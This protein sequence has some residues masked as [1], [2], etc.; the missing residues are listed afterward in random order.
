MSK[1]KKLFTLVGITCIFVLICAGLGIPAEKLPFAGQTVNISTIDKAKINGWLLFKDDIEKE[2][3]IKLNTMI[4][5]AAAAYEKQMMEFAAGTGAFDI[6]AFN[7]PW[8]GDYSR[9]LQPL[10]PLAEKAG[11]NFYLDDIMPVFRD[12]YMSWNGTW[13]AMTWD[14]DT[15]LLLYRKDIFD[16]LGLEPPTTWEDYKNK[17]AMLTGW[18]WDDDGE[19]EYGDASYLKR[20]RTYWWFL[21]RFAG[22]GGNYFDEEMNPLINTEAG[23]EALTNLVETI[24]YM[25]PG[26]LNFE[27]WEVRT[28]YVKGDVAMVLQWPCV[29]KAAEN[30]EES[31]IVGKGGYAAMPQGKTMIAGGWVL[32]I[33]KGAKHTEAALQVLH[34][35]T[36]PKNDLRA[37]M[38]QELPTALDPYRMSHFNSPIFRAA[39]P[40]AGDYLDALKANIAQGFPDLLIH[41][42]AEYM[43]VLDYQL[44]LAYAKE[45]SPQAALDDAA[46][47]W[48]KITRKLGEE[49]QKKEWLSQL[50]TMAEMKM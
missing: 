28:A 36:S 6:V 49:K 8:I 11:L 17:A 16:K 13:Y 31:K 39:W 25:P 30:P 29:G 47:Q 50:K 18:D 12:A 33:P 20:G 46:A 34:F 38:E 23:V 4:V 42:A 32:G 1:A 40:T 14:G 24:P 15:H 10:K 37:V 3:G 43:D 7:P 19:V 9:F 26:V 2:Y 27:Y 45:K 35:I 48:R 21:E 41:G 44:T 5:S 22:Y